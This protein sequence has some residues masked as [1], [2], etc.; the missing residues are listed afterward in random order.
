[1]I[2]VAVGPAL[3]KHGVKSCKS[4]QDNVISFEYRENLQVVHDVLIIKYTQKI[5]CR[6]VYTCCY[7]KD[8]R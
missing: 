4:G 6:S 3:E 8:N 2:W 5:T 1:M 7:F